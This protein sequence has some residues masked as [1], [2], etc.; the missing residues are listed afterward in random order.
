MKRWINAP[1]DLSFY[2]FPLIL[3]IN[4]QNCLLPAALGWT[5][6]TLQIST[7]I[8]VQTAKKH[9]ANPHVSIII[10]FCLWFFFASL[11][12]EKLHCQCS[13]PSLRYLNRAMGLD[14]L[15]DVLGF[16]WSPH[17]WS[18]FIKSQLRILLRTKLGGQQNCLQSLQRGMKV[19]KWG[20]LQQRSLHCSET[21]EGWNHRARN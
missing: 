11:F 10:D 13:D 8:T 21:E 9:T 20:V 17:A 18:H 2:F 7:Y 6:T 1:S 3:F 12:K 19:Q 15:W 16:D 5:K 14:V 4:C